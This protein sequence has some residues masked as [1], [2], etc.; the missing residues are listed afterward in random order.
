MAAAAQTQRPAAARAVK[1]ERARRCPP[2]TY[3]S[4]KQ[5]EPKIVPGHDRRRNKG[6]SYINCRH[7]F[8]P[9]PLIVL[10]SKHSFFALLRLSLF[11]GR[12]AVLPE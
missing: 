11:F 6:A 1:R 9:V 5:T 4:S 12:A 3:G 10:E 7:G 8:W 2:P